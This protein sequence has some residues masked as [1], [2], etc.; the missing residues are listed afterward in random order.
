MI[1]SEEQK[2]LAIILFRKLAENRKKRNEFMKAYRTSLREQGIKQK[3][4]NKKEN[5]T[6]NC[7]VQYHRQNA[8]V[9][10]K[11]LF[12]G[13]EM[14]YGFKNG[15][16][17]LGKQEYIYSAIIF[18]ETTEEDFNKVKPSYKFKR[19]NRFY[20]QKI[21]CNNAITRNKDILD[22]KEKYTVNEQKTK[23]DFNK[24]F[25]ILEKSETE[26]SKLRSFLRTH[27]AYVDMILVFSAFKYAKS[28]NEKTSMY[29]PT[30]EE[31]YNSSLIRAFNSK[32]TEYTFNPESKT[33]GGM[34]FDKL[35]HSKDAKSNSCYYNIIY[36]TY[37]P[38]INTKT[39]PD[40]KK[41]FKELTHDRMCEMMQ[42]ENKYEN[43]GLSIRKSIPFFL[44]S[45]I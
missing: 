9:G 11:H 6:R 28:R 8:L 4:C 43:L 45:I 18:Q 21:I 25:K 12:K 31:M 41:Y 26:P 5:N 1:F 13:D 34:F 20:K 42:I 36:S 10:V 33:F 3:C 15:C 14:F 29:E 39:K 7:N 37:A 17:M 2:Q 23:K 38:Q 22:Y 16:V 44:K 30:Q 32:F 19:N 24:L 27:L 35:A 40:G